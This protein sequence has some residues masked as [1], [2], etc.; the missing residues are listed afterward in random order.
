VDLLV[1]SDS[2]GWSDGVHFYN[3]IFYADGQFS[4][5][6]GRAP[7]GAYTTAPGF[8]ASRNHIFD[9]NVYYGVK[10]GDDPHAQTATPRLISP[11][12]ASLGREGLIGY[13]PQPGS[14]AVDSG[15]FVENNGGRDLFGNVVPS[16]GG[17]DRGAVESNVCGSSQ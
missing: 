11:G 8:G 5:A 15:R 13:G 16:C 1:F 3:N 10:P 2:N 9:S 7:D 6:T 4:H 17:V 14:P 12:K